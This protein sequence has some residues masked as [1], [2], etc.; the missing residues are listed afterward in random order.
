[1]IKWGSM[2]LNLQDEWNMKN[3]D[4]VFTAARI[5]TRGVTT[6]TRPKNPTQSVAVEG[7]SEK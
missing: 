6:C 5:K 1:M 7:S 2:P 3:C 4:I